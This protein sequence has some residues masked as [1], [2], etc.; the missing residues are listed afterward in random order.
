[1]SANSQACPDVDEQE[2]QAVD[3]V[4]DRLAQGMAGLHDLLGD[5]PG[6]V[7]LE[8]GWRSTLAGWST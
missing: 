1:M 3:D 5:A 6:E 2:P 8:E 7:V 4:D